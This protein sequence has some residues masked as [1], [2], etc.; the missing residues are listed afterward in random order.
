MESI[1]SAKKLSDSPQDSFTLSPASMRDAIA[2]SG[3]ALLPFFTRA[4]KLPSAA[5]MR[6]AVTHD[7]PPQST[8]VNTQP[9]QAKK[10]LAEWKNCT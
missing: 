4:R 6:V 9:R 10:K 1:R 8:P 2:I 5:P 3:S 7:Q